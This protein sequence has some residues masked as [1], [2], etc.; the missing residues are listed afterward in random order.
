MTRRLLAALMLLGLAT[1][2]AQAAESAPVRSAR[3]TAS[4][5]S[6]SDSVAPGQPVTVG[7]RLRMAPGWHTYWRNPGD[8]GVAAELAWSL[9]PGVSV[10]PIA[11]PAP[12]RMR[13]GPLMTFGY[14]GDVLLPV[15][16][17]PAAGSRAP[18]Q[19]VL[20]ANWLVCAKICV[21]EQ[22]SFNMTLPPGDGAASAQA[23]LFADAAARV[24]VASPFA[25]R[26]APDGTLAL[27]GDGLSSAGVADAWFM[28]ATWGGIDNAGP[29]RLAV[30]DGGLTLRLPLEHG[31]KP[32]QDLRGVLV[33]RD[34][35][36]GERA[37]DIDATPGAVPSVAATAPMT[38][39]PAWQSLLL[40]LAGGLLLNLMPCVF[41]VLAMKALAL[42]RLAGRDRATVRGHALS[43]TAGVLAAFLALAGA[44]LALQ[45]AGI[46]AG[47]GFQFQSPALV[48]LM[49]WLLFAI[50]LNLAGVFEVGAGRLANA[51]AALANR[52]GHAGSFC[53]GLLAVVVA[54]PCTAPFMGAALGAALAGPPA[55]AI[56]IFLALG[57][58]LASPYALLAVFPSL[59]RL[60]P[61]PGAWMDVLR[62][63]LAFPIFAACVWLVWVVSVQAGPPGVLAVCAGAGLLGFAGW[64]IG[65]G[66]RGGRASRLAAGVAAAFAVLATA[67]LL[68]SL[69]AAP[70]PAAAAVA[71]TTLPGEAFSAGRLAELRA[72]G[73]P[74]FVNLTAAWCVSCLVNERVALSRDAVRDAFAAGHVAY[75]VGDWTRADAGITRFLHDQGRDGVPLYIFYPPHAAGVV[76]PQILT[77][78]TVLNTLVQSRAQQ[79]S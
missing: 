57:A 38:L 18:L 71:G 69:A 28:P 5:V 64:A 46:A 33:L 78:A 68:P 52:H 61:R 27:T 66:Q 39:L 55:L 42:A 40:A 54:T 63:A 74:V 3:L 51:G 53:T 2:P 21:P 34:P 7:L 8:A 73:R 24:P 60:L 16:I 12:A 76:L 23:P 6:A 65:R 44:L 58:G 19:L 26:I 56:G 72:S 14:T 37:L 1:P 10:G 45:A 67:G 4:L 48:A 9:P 20:T 50:G 59:A 31:F 22:G 15:T 62:Q 75:L 13:E 70:P 36:G 29:Q 79:G 43:Y 17:T 77:E 35:Q 41:P 49:A 25:A 47:W 11:W 32:T 30:V